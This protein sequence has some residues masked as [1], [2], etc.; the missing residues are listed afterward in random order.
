M[1]L[2]RLAIRYQPIVLTLAMLVMGWGAVS[3]FTMPRREDPEFIVRICVVT[4]AWPGV[5]AEKIEQLV[6]DKIEEQLETIEDVQTIT[7]TTINGWSTIN[8]ELNDNYP[9]DDIQNA[10]DKIRAKVALARMPDPSI[11]PVVNDGFGD[12]TILLMAVHQIPSLGRDTIRP[13]DQYSPR[14]LEQYADTLRDSLRIAPG[15]A[16]VDKYGVSNEALYVETDAANWSRLDLTTRRLKDLLSQRNIVATGGE[17]DTP[18]GRFSVKP[19]GELDAVQEIESIIVDSVEAGQSSNPVYLGD[20][21]LRVRRGYQDPPAYFCRVGKPDFSAD[22][23]MLGIKMKSGENIVDVCNAAKARIERL[24]RVEQSLP[25]DIGITLVSDHSVNVTAKIQN[26]VVNVIEAVIIVVVVVLL[27]V[28]LRPSL[29]MAANIPIV[30]LASIGLIAAMGVQLEQISLASIIIALGLLV[31]NAVQV[32]DQSR[33]N[34]IAGMEPV[35]ATVEGARTLAMPMLVGTLTTIAAFLP[36]IFALEGSSGE[37]VYSLPVTLSVTLA[38][39]WILAMTLCV[40]L[41]SWFI[42]AP[43]N[44]PLPGDKDFDSAARPKQSAWLVTLRSLPSRFANLGTISLSLYGKV[45]HAAIRM[46]WL[47]LAIA[48]ALFVWAVQLP[49]ESENFPTDRRDQFAVLL[50]L[51]ETATIEQTN[52]KAKQVEGIIRALSP[53]ADTADNPSQR[54]RSM[55]TLV[56]G[57]GARWHLSWAPESRQPNFA[58]ILVRTTDGRFTPQYAQAVRRACESGDEKRGILPI[59]GASVV[60]KEL[61]LGPPSDP[62]VFRVIGDGFADIKTLRSLATK[63]KQIV[64]SQPETWNVHDSWG[65]SGYQLD[66]QPDP[67]RA[68]LAGVTNKQIAET[69]QAYFSGLQ[70]TTFLEDD[71]QIPVFFRLNPEDRS[72][73]RGLPT[74]Y[75]EGE[76]GKIPLETV[77]N[78]ESR[79]EPAKIERRDRNRVI[80]VRASMEPG[81]PGNDVTN[82]IFA[83]R[84]VQAIIDSLPPGFRV[85]VGGAVEDSVTSTRQMLTSFGISFL[86]IVLCLVFQYNAWAK[87]LIILTTLP[88]ALIGAL[89]G[90]YFTGN[91]IGFMPQLGILSL[92]GIVLNTGVIFVEFVDILIAEKRSRSSR[93]GATIS[94]L[95]RDEFRDCLVAAGKMRMLPIFLTTSTTIGGLIPL[96]LGGGPLWTGL[97]WTMIFGLTV[98]TALTLLVVPAIYAILV[99]TFGVQPIAATSS[100]PA[101]VVSPVQSTVGIGSA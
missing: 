93:P 85:E 24:Q 50:R 9:G 74:A 38:L 61:G 60:P 100:T 94:G 10:W 79:W 75:V 78:I 34:Q 62:L 39:S 57:G 49:V 2:S 36:M 44:E 53:V 51:P 92:F 45:A 89:P 18:S 13:R 95:T 63:L 88:M 22:A 68:N 96:A 71:D 46:K 82:R 81:A 3:F 35:E 56:G 42:R 52:E 25:P 55:R 31:D 23:I 16:S 11:R 97:A 99:E 40:I 30:V 33:T 58:E 41:A 66:V 65:A 7:S 98:A 1:N 64:R 91:L 17:I 87:P 21:G 8:V 26:V 5:P 14:E 83:S 48:I 27:F 4:T 19:G 73:V 84:E 67:D 80:E 76:R 59:R 86:L 101:S 47:T 90:L 54:L 70:L 43:K 6:T 28:G 12:T 20:L 15:V 29:V 37:F 72:D 77:A 69:L 32:C